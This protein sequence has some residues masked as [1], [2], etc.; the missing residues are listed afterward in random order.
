MNFVEANAAVQVLVGLV[1]LAGV[2]VSQR[3]TTA[4]LQENQKEILR[5]VTA[6]HKR[7]DDHARRIHKTEIHGAV[8]EERVNFLRD[9]RPRALR[10]EP[11]E[12]EE[13]E[14]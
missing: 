10:E 13:I 8:L 12:E 5:Q 3:I 4:K 1:I 14:G 11:E 9:Q 2:I 6:L 7:I